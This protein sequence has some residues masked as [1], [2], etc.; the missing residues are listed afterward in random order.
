MSDDAREREQR[1][2]QTIG[3][4]RFESNWYLVYCKPREDE[5]ALENLERQGFQCYRP[6]LAIEQRRVNR[7]RILDRPLFPGYIF[8][9]LDHVRDNWALIRSTRGVIHLVRFGDYPV[10]VADAVI[11]RIRIRLSSVEAE[12]Y[13][14][15]GEHVR[16]TEGA[17]SQ[18][19]A[20]FVANDGDQR[21]ILL[22]NVLQ[23]DQALSFP[24]A[25]IRKIG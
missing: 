14:K 8:I 21:V 12:P 3:I 18:L 1:L 16:I 23:T 10:R 20:I 13:L 2:H 24:L 4:S 5:R 9:Q 11:D 15:P 6:V 19:E 17:F 25:S 7:K 22:L